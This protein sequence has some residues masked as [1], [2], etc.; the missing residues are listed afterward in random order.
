MFRYPSRPNVKVL[1]GL[2]LHI[3]AGKTV[4]LVGSSGSGKSTISNIVLRMYDISSGLI[5]VD[6]S[7][8]GSLSS[9]WL[10]DNITVVEQQSVL[11]NTTIEENIMLGNQ[12]T[13]DHPISSD[14]MKQV[15]DFAL[16]QSIIDTSS[17]GL[18]TVVGIGGSKLSGGQRQRI[19]LARARIRDTPILILDESVSA[20]ESA[21]RDKIMRETRK[22]RRH[23]TT[24]IITH[25]LAQIHD[26]DYVYVLADGKTLDHGL[27]KHLDEET[28]SNPVSPIASPNST[29]TPSMDSTIFNSSS[30]RASYRS[31]LVHSP[32]SDY[33]EINA[34]PDSV[35]LKRR[36]MPV[37][38]ETFMRTL[39]IPNEP[40][41]PDLQSQPE[42]TVRYSKFTR[43][44][45]FRP[46]SALYFVPPVVEPSQNNDDV[47]ELPS[48]TTIPSSVTK[49][50]QFYPSLFPHNRP[51][52]SSPGY[53]P[54]KLYLPDDIASRRPSM[55]STIND[56][57]CLKVMKYISYSESSTYIVSSFPILAMCYKRI[58][59]KWLLWL[60]IITA[61]AN[62]ALT[63]IFSFVVA[64][65]MTHMT[66]GANSSSP[67]KWIALALTLAVVDGLTAFVRTLVLGVVSDRWVRDLRV[68]AFSVIMQQDMDWYTQNNIDTNDLTALI[69]SHSEDMRS[70]V[71][72][73]L[74]I[75]STTI[76]LSLI[77]IIWVMI[78]G[79]K[80][81]LVG[82]SLVP[83]FYLSAMFS[84]YVVVHWEGNCIFLNAI[85]EEIIHE[86]V[87]SIRTLRI[88]GLEKVFVAK[89]DQG[90]ANFK[91]AKFIDCIFSGLGFGIGEMVPFISQG[92]LLWYGMKLI[93]DTDYTAQQVLM[94]FTILFFS[95]SS[96][97]ALL[98]AV[99]Q[100]HTTFLVCFRLFQLLNFDMSLT[101]EK[102]GKRSKVR[103]DTGSIVFSNV[104]FSYVCP[105]GAIE[106]EEVDSSV[107]L[108]EP[109]SKRQRVKALF[110]PQATTTSD[111]LLVKVL[112][113]FTA[114]IPGNKTT[115]IVGPSGSGKST[116]VSLL[117]KLYVP[118][119]GSIKIDGIDLFNI[120]TDILRQE[121]AVV[122]QMPLNFFGGTIYE[123]I[124]FALNRAQHSDQP[125]L[126]SE[127]RRVCQECSIDDF[128]SSLPDGYDTRIGGSTG[129]VSSG[130]SALLSGGQ[131]QRI[132]IARAL[133]RQPRILILDECTS[134]L[135]QQSTEAIKET[136]VAY[137]KNAKSR[138]TILIITH[139]QD[140][141]SIA[142][143]VITLNEGRVVKRVTQ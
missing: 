77:C 100:L 142:D 103:M 32:F 84:K 91:K 66:L 33:F 111:N 102:S 117:T 54:K 19:A 85:V 89:F 51:I 104:H 141:A 72:T 5:L 9:K 92:I 113:S 64:N 121:I 23:K 114:I 10:R 41:L 40:H 47:Y 56:D 116:L 120:D 50:Q 28:F 2:D 108:N 123:N 122:G 8:I 71:T 57:F 59:D 11:F 37:N 78:V 18:N 69:M 134:G 31:S 137:K 70:I 83:I 119:G 131:M 55:S 35:S 24:I 109:N 7:P 25:E 80:L 138:M 29:Y 14:E 129:P 63:P 90:V 36:T 34:R 27:R 45:V 126:L 97:G 127:V 139:Q 53:A 13:K 61:I 30:K 106:D 42:E 76:S 17:K 135:D 52:S 38:L 46:Q 4:F 16:L 93:A 67:K 140:V 58:N 20:L 49:H 1:D 88:L 6:G 125:V 132:G 3:P 74:N 99:P 26:D 39:P 124:T 112:D 48:T 81:G 68:K 107:N 110:A 82:I 101:H 79:W 62:G 75:V 12:N 21:V 136:L 94:V 43:T 65:L 22:W 98:T 87:S 130:G 143:V 96:I 86:T 105:P 115:A 128:I 118:T 44:S 133:I 15:I 95:I 73:F 60:G